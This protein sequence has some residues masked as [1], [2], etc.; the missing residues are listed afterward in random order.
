MTHEK[1]IDTGTGEPAVVL[2][3]G[4]CCAPTDYQWHIDA[5]SKMHRVIAP[6]LRGHGA[7]SRDAKPEELTVE[8]LAS[9]VA[10]LLTENAIT[11]AVL[12]GHSMGVRVILEV[13]R[14]VP[15]RVAGLVFLDGSNTVSNNLT[16]VLDEFEVATSDGKIEPWTQGLFQ[17]MFLPDT[18]KT[19]QDMYQQRVAEMPNA[20][21]SALYRNMIIW[22]AQ[23]FMPQLKMAASKPVLVVQSTVRVADAPR[24][25]LKPGEIGQFPQQVA[26]CHPDTTI[27]TYAHCGH[28]L[29]LDEPEQLLE[30]I[31]SWMGESGLTNKSSA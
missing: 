30:D 13:H 21:L 17:Q 11:N 18:F 19:Q 5:L 8:Q 4:F 9:D 7:S 16:T 12:C 22:D 29:N 26:E 27:V 14:Q 15:D 23:Q 25:S 10:Q 2:I 20:N 3:H 6:T 24:R 1:T 28:F 31:S